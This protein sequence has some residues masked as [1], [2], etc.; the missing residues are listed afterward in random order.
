[1]GTN[2]SG[3]GIAPEAILCPNPAPDALIPQYPVRI[4]QPIWFST[5]PT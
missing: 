1:M 4:L 5:I 3:W 2:F